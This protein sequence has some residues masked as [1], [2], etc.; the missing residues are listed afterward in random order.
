M[1]IIK[2]FVKIPFVP[3]NVFPK[4]PLP[5]TTFLFLRPAF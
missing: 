1:D 2:M 3:N 4:T 5:D